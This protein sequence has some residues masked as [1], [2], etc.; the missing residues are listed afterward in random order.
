MI[1]SSPTPLRWL[2]YM[3]S[4]MLRL[5]CASNSATGACERQAKLGTSIQPDRF[6]STP[7]SG[8]LKTYLPDCILWK[9]MFDLW[10]PALH[11]SVLHICH[12]YLNDVL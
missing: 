11:R 5:F 1:Y 4:V 8:I 3:A 12:A 6:L 7:T 2:D 10:T 9:D